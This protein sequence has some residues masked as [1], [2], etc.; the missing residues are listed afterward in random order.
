MGGPENASAL[1]PRLGLKEMTLGPDAHGRYWL[2]AVGG[3]ETEL[4]AGCALFLR[5]RSPVT[6]Q[7]AL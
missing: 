7:E 4:P 6:G 2:Q 1:L 3:E 5:G